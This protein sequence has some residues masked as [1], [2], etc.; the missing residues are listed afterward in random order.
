M[1]AL[2]NDGPKRRQV[3]FGQ[4]RR[5]T[6]ERPEDRSD[7]DTDVVWDAVSRDIPTLKPEIEHLLASLENTE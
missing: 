1:A 7:I 6:P 3:R 5:A 2:P 4:D